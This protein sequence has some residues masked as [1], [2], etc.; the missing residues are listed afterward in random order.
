MRGLG[1]PTSRAC[2][3][4]RTPS[5]GPLLGSNRFPSL[6]KTASCDVISVSLTLLR[7][8]PQGS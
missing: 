1:R 5:P 8:Q 2:A 3:W 4:G 7:S 6:S